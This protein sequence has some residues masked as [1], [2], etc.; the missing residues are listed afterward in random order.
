MGLCAIN[1]HGVRPGAHILISL[2]YK[3]LSIATGTRFLCCL[4]FMS[5][6]KLGGRDRFFLI[7]F[8]LMVVR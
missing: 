8:L 5:K 2:T 6:K 7:H 3:P 1:F 4:V